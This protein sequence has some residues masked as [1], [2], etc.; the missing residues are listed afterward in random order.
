M[1]KYYLEKGNFKASLKESQTAL[2][3]FPR[4]LGDQAL[5]QIGLAHAHPDNPDQNLQNSKAAFQKLVKDYPNSN[6]RTQAELW[7]IQFRRVQALETKLNTKK[8]EIDKLQDRMKK[9]Q[10]QNKKLQKEYLQK[11]KAH[12]KEIREL[13][14]NIKRLKEIDL[15]IDEKK[16]K[17]IH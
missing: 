11:I 10:A 14:N 13:K 16:R 6:L 1:S 4:L 15:K 5:F 2:E 7:I 9:N 8:K 3:L 12:E 17:A